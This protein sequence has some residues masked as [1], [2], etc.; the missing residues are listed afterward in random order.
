MASMLRGWSDDVVVLTGG[1]G[2]LADEHI[3]QLSAQGIAVC[4]RE[5]SELVSARG[6]LSEWCS[7]TEP[8]CRAVG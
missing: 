3:A 2:G 6:E 8:G 7:P 5:V 4:D 1:A